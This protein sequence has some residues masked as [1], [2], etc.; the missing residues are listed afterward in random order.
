MFEPF[1]LAP[2]HQAAVDNAGMIILIDNGVIAFLHEGRDGADI[3]L[4]AGREDQRRLF[5]DE[6]RQAPVELKVKLQRAV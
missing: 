2:T 3:C 6:L 1:H 5:P 4:V